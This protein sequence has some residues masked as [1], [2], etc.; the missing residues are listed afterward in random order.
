MTLTEQPL[1]KEGAY[2]ENEKMRIVTKLETG[3]KKI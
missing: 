1:Y 2:D 3:A